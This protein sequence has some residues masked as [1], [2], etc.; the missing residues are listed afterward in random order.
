LLA[1]AAPTLAWGKL[2][3]RLAPALRE[4]AVNAALNRAVIARLRPCDVIIGMSGIYLEALEQAK[5]RYGARVWLERGSRHILS[6]D[7]ILA[8]L[9]GAQRPGRYAIERELAGYALADRIV[10]PSEHAARSFDR[11]ASARAK[12]FR[13]PYGVDLA[14]F[15]PRSEP[16]PPDGPLRL[17]NVGAWSRRKGSDLLAEV[18]A[19]IDGVC[20]SH[21]GEVV[22]VPFPADGSRFVHAPAVSQEQLTSTYARADALVLFSWEEGLS[23]TLAQALASGLPIICSDRTGGADLAHTPNLA[24]RITVVPQGDT[25]ALASAIM[26]VRDRLSASPPLA[27]LAN[28]DL[29]SLSWAAY[30]RRYSEE[31][32]RDFAA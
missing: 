10:V 5:S 32:M 26:A 3:P 23:L 29:E 6:Q 4:R 18:V 25:H 12:I 15:P 11:D 28:T 16:R 13:N 9:P 1:P 27:P 21:V 22:D 20:L 30:G 14:M 31:L 7:E 2:A 24:D 8:A 17:L 19:R